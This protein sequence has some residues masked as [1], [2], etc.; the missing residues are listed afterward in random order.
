MKEM[1]AGLSSVSNQIEQSNT[2]IDIIKG[3]LE[4][5]EKVNRKTETENNKKFEEIRMEIR[6]NK[7]KMEN[8]ITQNVITKL[9]PQFEKSREDNL[10]DIRRIV[11]KCHAIL[12]E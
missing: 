7:E 12:R 4:V 3:R 2:N 5:M 8:K 9:Q 11:I 1:C 10:H 6:E